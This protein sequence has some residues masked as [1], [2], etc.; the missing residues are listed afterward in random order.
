MIK[1]VFKYLLYVI[2]LVCLWLLAWF[3][4][5]LSGRPGWFTWV[6]F[7]AVISIVLGAAFLRRLW[8]RRQA[9]VAALRNILVQPSA[10]VD[11][12]SSPQSLRQHW[13]QELSQLRSSALGK[14]G[15]PRYV[16]PWFLMLGGSG[17]GK[18]AALVRSRVESAII[19][20]DPAAP[21]NPTINCDWYLFDNAIVLDS[22]GRYAE[23]DASAATAEEWETL[24]E[25]ISSA[26][27]REPLNGVIITIAADTLLSS[28]PDRVLEQARFLRKRLVQLMTLMNTRFPVY[29]LVTKIDRLY[30][31]NA[32]AKQLPQGTLRQPMGYFQ[33]PQV[34]DSDGVAIRTFLDNAFSAIVGT[35]KDLRL[36]VLQRS[37]ATDTSFMLFPNELERL[38][39]ALE[40]FFGALFGPN[41]YIQSPMLRGLLFSSAE[42]TGDESSALLSEVDAGAATRPLPGT[43]N[44]AFLH[45]F[46]AR[47][48]PQE[49]R[50]FTSLGT[51]WRWDRVTQSLGAIS[52]L[53]LNLAVVV[54]L[55][56]SF[57]S[58]F[59]TVQKARSLY[60]TYPAMSGELREDLPKLDQFRGFIEWMY[61]RENRSLTHWTP[62]HRIID[63]LHEN[64]TQRFCQD[65]TKFVIP[66]TDDLLE[67]QFKSVDKDDPA[68]SLYA[69]FASTRINL[70]MARTNGMSYAQMRG[71]PL[72]R[73]DI[74]ARL[75]PHITPELGATFAQLYVANVAWKKWDIYA[76]LHLVDL[77]KKLDALIENGN[78]NMSWLVQ[79]G[80]EFSGLKPVTL[81]KFWPGSTAVP[82]AVTVPPAFTAAGKQAIAAFL[83]QMEKATM[84]SDTLRIYERTFEKWYGEQQID[85]WY[86]F[87]ANFD[88]GRQ[89]L[90]DEAQWRRLMPIIESGSGPY[91]A[92]IS[93]IAGNLGNDNEQPMP[94][95]VAAPKRFNSLRVLSERQRLLNSSAAAVAG[96]VS[97]TGWQ[98]FFDTLAGRPDQG[99]A[100]VTE[101]LGEAKVCLLYMQ[102]LDA[103][104]RDA[105]TNSAQADKIA[106]AFYA[107]ASNPKAEPSAL[108]TLYGTLAELIKQLGAD[109]GPVDPVIS[110]LISGPL[111]FIRAYTDRQTA[112]YLQTVWTSDVLWPLNKVTT[113]A[114]L[115]DLLYGSKGTVWVFID[116]PGGPFVKRN[117][118]VYSPVD[119]MG[120]KI[121][122][123]QDF[124]SYLNGAND[125]N[126]IRVTQQKR[127]A[128][129]QQQDQLALK[130]RLAAVNDLLAKLKPQLDNLRSSQANVV[131]RAFPTSVNHGARAFPYATILTLQCASGPLTM[132]NYN[133]PVDK[134]FAWSPSTC[135]DTTLKVQFQGLTLTRRYTGPYGFAKF[136][137]EFRDGRYE[138]TPDDFAEANQQMAALGVKHLTIYYS[139]EGQ[140]PVLE[141]YNLSSMLPERINELEAEQ[142]DLEQ[143][144]QSAQQEVLQ[145]DIDSFQ[146]VAPIRSRVPKQVAD[147]WG[148][149]TVVVDDNSNRTTRIVRFQDN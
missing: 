122:F 17:S 15:D 119:M 147:C 23:H 76:T 68:Y 141:Q 149:S 91:F 64:F 107:F 71:M 108:Y 41:P 148:S 111:R 100:K 70:N 30:G 48:L 34:F 146:R 129:A 56:F 142:S 121:P 18:T 7:F 52:W 21:V 87:A 49:R 57:L 29:V 96:A 131:I 44:G 102:G 47:I 50:V 80:D 101:R 126:V 97:Q 58:A 117:A 98:A 24:L 92:L 6:F 78:P 116:G 135:G 138:F 55:S 140:E 51:R 85:A 39:P 77:R 137:K 59:E 133:F 88:Q 73:A 69:Y 62:F 60:P 31:L 54:L 61:E 32:L 36:A 115:D 66:E 104:A 79:W 25:L 28:N 124:L 112:C 118:R 123:A 128:I 95:W 67:K 82:G 11:L 12:E 38:R 33:D 2:G 74:L 127:V 99:V 65:F 93:T 132:S 4:A 40:N 89:L 43:A 10:A 72:P 90:A 110:A 105:S 45:D 1:K 9:R 20:V 134:I 81:G 130:N 86:R 136:L 22:A 120:A 14:S 114:E 113:P 42:Q 53:V 109:G 144:L 19:D 13:K 8:L 145:D 125:R 5:M 94:G 63:R 3:V 83:S 106:A 27:R 26:R 46:F 103:L 37:D 16:L 139:L 84:A 143:Q 35:L 75:D